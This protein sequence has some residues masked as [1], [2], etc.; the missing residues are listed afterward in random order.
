MK[1]LKILKYQRIPAMQSSVKD[2]MQCP[3]FCLN[4]GENELD[5]AKSNLNEDIGFVFLNC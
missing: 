1:F 4:K 5:N 2:Q 3:S